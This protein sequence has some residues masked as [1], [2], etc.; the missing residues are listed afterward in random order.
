MCSEVKY[1]SFLEDG[2]TREEIRFDDFL[3][4]YVNHRP[5]FGVGKAQ[6]QSAF[7]ALAEKLGRRGTSNG[8][9]PAVSWSSLQSILL[10][11]EETMTK[12]EL[13]SCLQSLLGDEAEDIGGSIGPT[14][15]SEEVLGFEDYEQE[16]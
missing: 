12:E 6:I 5:V 15:F 1:A 4:L 11:E 2:L 14:T 13:M 10:D 7:E 8:D 9:A 16:K 3:A